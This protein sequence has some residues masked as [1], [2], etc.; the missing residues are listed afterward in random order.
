MDAFAFKLM[1]RSQ[2]NLVGVY[3][4]LKDLYS[5]MVERCPDGLFPCVVEGLRGKERQAEL[6]RAGLSWTNQSRHLTGEA[7]DVVLFSLGP[8]GIKVTYEP[9]DYGRFAT[10]CRLPRAFPGLVWGGEL[11]GS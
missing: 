7:I 3:D 11:E 9:S 2:A 10:A 1:T 6:R 5:H 4:G 8:D